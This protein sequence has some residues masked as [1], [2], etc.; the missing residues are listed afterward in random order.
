VLAYVLNNGCT[1]EALNSEA[2]LTCDDGSLLAFNHSATTII[3]HIFAGNTPEDTA[4][5]SAEQFDVEVNEAL[6]DVRELLELL[7]KQGVLHERS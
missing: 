6:A 1:W 7:E 4:I 3:S 2:F 5:K